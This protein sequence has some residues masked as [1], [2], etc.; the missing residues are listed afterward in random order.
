MKNLIITLAIILSSFLISCASVHPGARGHSY[1]E[2]NPININVSAENLDYSKGDSFQL[3]EVT[4]ENTSEEWVRIESIRPR[5]PNPAE[6][7]VSAVLG[8]DLVDWA[9][10]KQAQA[11]VDKLNQDIIQASLMGAGVLAATSKNSTVS[12]L[13][14]AAALGGIGWA[15]VT[16]IT[17]DQRHAQEVIKV[18]STHLYAPVSVPAKMFLRRWLLL[19]KPP[20]A[21][22][23]TLVIDVTTVDGKRGVYEIPLSR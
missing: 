20:N 8:Q 15:A 14:S 7:K 23:T 22:L 6:S 9:E 16:G 5:L 3:I 18:P 10:A 4:I 1:E 13:G 2:P 21:E 19:N 11:K 17:A 12:A